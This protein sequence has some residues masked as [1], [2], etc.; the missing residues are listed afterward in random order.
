M[1]LRAGDI[2]QTSE[3]TPENIQYEDKVATV[4]RNPTDQ[5]GYGERDCSFLT[6][7]TKGILGDAVLRN[8]SLSTPHPGF[9]DTFK[10]EYPARNG[11]KSP[12]I[13]HSLRI[14]QEDHK[15]KPNLDNLAI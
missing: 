6:P 1:E 2:S 3:L 7:E 5:E 4:K 9:P 15:F 13:Q 10:T 8:S 12:T 11:W 14:R